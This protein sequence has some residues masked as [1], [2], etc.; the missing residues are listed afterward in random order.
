[1]VTDFLPNTLSS[2]SS[3]TISRLFFGFWRSCFLMYS[4]TL[5]TTS[6]RG[7]GFEPTTA[8]HSFDGCRGFISAGLTLRAVLFGPSSGFGHRSLPL[9]HNAIALWSLSA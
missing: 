8:A 2:L 7:S 6:G 9:V 1:M 4:H 5:L 3:A